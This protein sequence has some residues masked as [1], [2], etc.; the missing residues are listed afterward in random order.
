MISLI[1]AVT[2][3]TGVYTIPEAARYAKMPVATIRSWFFPH[4]KRKP[5]RRGSIDDAELKVIS[6]LDFV[7][8]LAVRSLRVDYNVSLAAIRNAIEFAHKEYRIDHIFAR[9]DH[10]T[11]LDLKKKQLH[12]VMAGEKNPISLS[13]KDAGQLSFH[14]CVEGYM[15][16]LNFNPEGIADLYT[17][18][19]FDGQEVVMKPTFN[20]G[21]PVMAENG[22][23]PAVLWRS[24]V[25][26]GSFE[27]AADLYDA[28]IESVRA[29][30][31]YCN[32]E[33][34]LVAA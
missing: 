26:E 22:Y 6:F 18:F 31:R 34:G 5:M 4:D 8:A 16:D 32:G 11:R 20:F 3:G 2:S 7:E 12:I 19:R 15:Q 24:V 1:D 23:P 28:S 21:G 33:L 25:T 17:A 9:R 13:A 27:R 10:R 29:A 14:E 30:Y